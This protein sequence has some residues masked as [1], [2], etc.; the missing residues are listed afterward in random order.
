MKKTLLTLLIAA[1]L[2]FSTGLNAYAVPGE[3]GNGYT[4]PPGQ[5]NLLGTDNA[6]NPIYVIEKDAGTP[7]FIGYS[8]GLSGKSQ[9]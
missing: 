5:T 8:Y 2:V 1:A 3:N 9:Q 6:G 4:L 7:D